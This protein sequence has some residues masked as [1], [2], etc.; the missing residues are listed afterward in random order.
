MCKQQWVCIGRLTNLVLT[1]GLPD[2]RQYGDEHVELLEDFVAQAFGFVSANAI[3]VTLVEQF[4]AAVYQ[5]ALLRLPTLCGKGAVLDTNL[6]DLLHLVRGGAG[7][8]HGD[9]E[10]R[11]VPVCVYLLDPNN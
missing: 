1:V 7:G 4:V 9:E 8:D 6:G 2:G 11:C 5:P 10:D 3:E